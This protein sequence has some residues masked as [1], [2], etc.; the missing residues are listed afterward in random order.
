M[1]GNAMSDSNIDDPVLQHLRERKAALRDDATARLMEVDALLTAL[2]DGRT[3]V[4]RRLVAQLRPG[5][6]AAAVTEPPEAA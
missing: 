5:E 1:R 2:S 3:R 6:Q 4:R